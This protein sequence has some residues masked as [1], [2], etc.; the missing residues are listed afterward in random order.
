[1]YHVMADGGAFAPTDRVELIGGELIDMSP[2]GKLHARC[3]KFLAK[4]LIRLL[5]DGYVVGVQDP[6]VLNDDSE[7]QPDLSIVRF[8]DD[9]Y[10]DE[11][12]G[13]KDVLL[14]IEVADTSVDFDRNVKLRKYAAAGIPESWLID[15]ASD[16][17]EAHTEPKQSGYGLVKIYGRGENAVSETIAA[18][19]LSVDEILG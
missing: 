7:P 6:I 10:K 1:M 8:K 18:I 16:R 13:S 2:I 17:V 9:F 5:S 19:D 15:L 11:L 4:Y 12:P 3:V 14:I